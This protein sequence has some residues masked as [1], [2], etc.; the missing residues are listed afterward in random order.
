MS[1]E[2]NNDSENVVNSKYYGIDQIQT[3]KFPGK[4]RYLILF[5][6]DA[7]SLNRNFEDLD[8]LLN[9]TNKIFDII[10]VSETSITKQISVTTNINLKNYTIQFTPTDLQL[11]SCYVLILIFLKLTS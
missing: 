8:H 1:P 11:G 2:K 3:L 9:C 6:I 7:C 10:A 4:H 5:H